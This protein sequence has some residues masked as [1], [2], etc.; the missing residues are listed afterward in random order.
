MKCLAVDKLSPP[1]LLFAERLLLLELATM[2]VQV[3]G[4]KKG[5]GIEGYDHKRCLNLR[6]CSRLACVYRVMD[7]RGLESTKNVKE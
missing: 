6:I 5:L 2:T 3:I 7:V 4:T 1:I